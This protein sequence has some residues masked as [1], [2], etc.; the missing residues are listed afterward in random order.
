MGLCGP[1]EG[2][3]VIHTKLMSS[4]T[5]LKFVSNESHVI[6]S[7]C[8]DSGSRLSLPWWSSPGLG[9]CICSSITSSPMVYMTQK[10]LTKN[11][12]NHI[13]PNMWPSS[14]PGLN[15]PNF[16]IWGIVKRETNQ[17]PH[18]TKY[19]FNATIIDIMASKNKN[20]LI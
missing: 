6:S 2:P 11:F 5:V 10:L 19:S 15:L 1:R 14:S 7:H 3:T 4:L 12:H 20:N 9:S 16:Y 18:N 8:K 13:S 17:W